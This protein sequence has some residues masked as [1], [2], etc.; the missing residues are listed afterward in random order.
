MRQAITERTACS[1]Y[2]RAAAP[3]AAP[4]AQ[5]IVAF[6]QVAENRIARAIVKQRLQQPFGDARGRGGGIAHDRS[7]FG[8]E[9]LH[10]A[11]HRSRS[12]RASERRPSAV[13]L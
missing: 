3:R 9:A 1:Q 5:R 10:H 6:V 13:S 8:F 4:L 12:D 7:S 11:A 2:H